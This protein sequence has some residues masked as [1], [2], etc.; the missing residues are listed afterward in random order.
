[1]ADFE[2]VLTYL[3]DNSA[4]AVT[5][6]N[7]P[8]D[9]DAVGR[10]ASALR[11]NRSLHFLELDNCNITTEGARVLAE[12]IAVHPS[13][14]SISL[15]GNQ[16]GD[17]GILAIFAALGDTVTELRL[18]GNPVSAHTPHR[19]TQLLQQNRNKTL[20]SLNADWGGEAFSPLIDHTFDTCHKLGAKCFIPP[21]ELPLAT[22]QEIWERRPAMQT[23]YGGLTRNV[24]DFLT[25]LPSVKTNASL[26]AEDLQKPEAAT[27]MAPLEN[28]LTWHRFS[29]ITAQLQANGAPLTPQHLQGHSDK[30]GMSHLQ[31][32]LICAPEQV[33]AFLNAHGTQLQAPSFLKEDGTPNELLEDFTQRQ[34]IH[35]IFTQANWQGEDG[36]RKMKAFFEKLPDDAKAQV[37]NRH[38]LN[39]ALHVN[40]RGLER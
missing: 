21:G 3:R 32:G 29:E 2:R 37:F 18:S 35:S 27:G 5:L 17:E 33:I 7:E 26:T 1:M 40:D 15:N 25:A 11:E 38:A 22:L 6:N 39:A 14:Q 36:A 19:A 30:W 16:I 20:I 34:K 28:P 31:C 23:N 24:S 8:L 12:S 4:E 9:D 13:L 10:L